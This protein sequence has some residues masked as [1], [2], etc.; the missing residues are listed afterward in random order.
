[1]HCLFREMSHLSGENAQAR[2]ITFV[3]ML[4]EHLQAN[5]DAQ[6]GLGCRRMGYSLVK[7]ARPEFAHAIGHCTLTGHNDP[8]GGSEHSRVGGYHY[9]VI[10]GNMLDGLGHRTQIAHAV[11]DDRDSF[12]LEFIKELLRCRQS[13]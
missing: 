13:G 8:I 9:L 1:M 6:E 11:I 5:A 7:T 12:H 2:D 4:K 10:R 3:T